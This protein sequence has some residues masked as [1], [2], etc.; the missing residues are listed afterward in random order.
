VHTIDFKA[1]IG[2]RKVLLRRRKNLK[3]NSGLYFR[4][5]VL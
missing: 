1:D 2:V 5:M 4:V 3:F